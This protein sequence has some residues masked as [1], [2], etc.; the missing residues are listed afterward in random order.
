VLDDRLLEVDFQGESIHLGPH[1]DGGLSVDTR[2]LPGGSWENGKE[3]TSKA[4]LPAGVV[5]GSCISSMKTR[6]AGSEGWAIVSG[7]FPAAFHLAST[8]CHRYR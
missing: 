5:E 1:A 3:L 6:F 2:P 4:V 8:N 7:I